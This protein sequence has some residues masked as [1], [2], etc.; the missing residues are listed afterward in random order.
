MSRD[1]QRVKD[2]CSQVR[3]SRV[4]RVQDRNRRHP[5]PVTID[6][7]ALECSNS[8]LIASVDVDWIEDNVDRNSYSSI[9]MHTEVDHSLPSNPKSR[10]SSKNNSFLSRTIIDRLPE[11]LAHWARRDISRRHW[12]PPL[13]FHWSR[14]SRS[15]WEHWKPETQWIAEEI[16]RD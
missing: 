15:A 9:L 7:K 2:I 16:V 3:V 1:N 5:V 11:D 12:M 10:E 8:K 13:S 14:R 6:R 4:R